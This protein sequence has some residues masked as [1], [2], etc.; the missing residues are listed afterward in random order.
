VNIKRLVYSSYLLCSLAIIPLYY[1]TQHAFASPSFGRQEIKDPASDFYEMYRHIQNRNA[2]SYVDIRA[3]N[4]FSDGR[5]LNTTIWL[6]SFQ[7]K[8]PKDR[9][10][11]YGVYIDSDHN[12]ETGIEGIDYKIEI[13]WE[14]STWT[15]VIEEWSSNGKVKNVEN[16]E[17]NY[18]GFF[19]KGSSYVL[20]SADLNSMISPSRYRVIF[21]AEEIKGLNWN[22][23]ATDWVHVPP[24][25]VSISTSPP[26]LDHVR[27]GDSQ[28]I[29]VKLNVTKGF[30]P[31]AHLY[32]VSTSPDITTRF[33]DDF[34]P[35]PSYGVTTTDL[36]ISTATNSSWGPRT[37]LIFADSSLPSER[38]EESINST[39]L[40]PKLPPNVESEDIVS[41]SSLTINVDPPLSFP[42]YLKSFVTDWFTPI[43][44]IITTLFSI[45]TGLFG[46]FIGKSRS[47]NS[48]KKNDEKSHKINGEDSQK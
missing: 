27:A 10:V 22:M 3:V 36:K 18:S 9:N 31:V 37:L 17:Q 38:I 24:P 35:V 5:C 41:Q 46:Y 13:S 34:L 42:D 45:G 30:E 11:N 33:Q 29:E 1:D 6:D 28:T 26:L 15:K 12:N 25:Q 4:Y 7:E 16:P 8:P 47:K 44:T 19:G 32:T 2:S 21:Y 48:E 39:R 43:T 14:N 20:L 23:D 40:P